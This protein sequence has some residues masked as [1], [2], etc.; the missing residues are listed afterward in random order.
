MKSGS[1]FTQITTAEV[2]VL[3]MRR[4]TS[5]VQRMASEQTLLFKVFPLGV[6][7]LVRQSLRHE[8]P[9]AKRHSGGFSPLADSE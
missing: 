9:P 7:A 2:T 4:D 5:T 1:E 3:E 6:D 8:P